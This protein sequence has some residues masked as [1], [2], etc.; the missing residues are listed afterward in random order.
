MHV[1]PALLRGSIFWHLQFFRDVN[2]EF[3]ANVRMFDGDLIVGDASASEAKSAPTVRMS[4][5]T[6]TARKSSASKV[7]TVGDAEALDN[8]ALAGG[9]IADLVNDFPTFWCALVLLLRCFVLV[10]VLFVCL[11][12][13]CCT[14]TR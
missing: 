8:S 5:P 7:A 12:S 14:H 1:F 10:I 2:G 4:S 6:A 13:V 3:A 11:S 9:V